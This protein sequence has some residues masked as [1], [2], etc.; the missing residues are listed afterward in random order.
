LT[1]S[2][3]A[4]EA[5]PPV[6]GPHRSSPCAARTSTG[7]RSATLRIALIA[8][9]RY[10][11]REPFA[12]GLEAHSWQLARALGERG[13]DVCV[14]AGPGSDPDLHVHE[15]PPMP[16][17]SDA[18]RK[19]VSMPPEYFL[20]E[21]S[22]YLT[23]MLG[24]LDG[25]YDVVHNN[26]LHYLPIAMA[27]ALGCPMLTTLHTPPTPWIESA[28]AARP[29][30]RSRFAAVSRV[31]AEQW[32]PTIP[33]P[34]VV[35]NGIDLARW[36]PGPGGGVPVWSGRIVPEKGLDLAIE[37]AR[38]AGTGLRIAGPRPDAGYFA[39]C[40]EPR[41]GDGIEYLG[42]LDHRRLCS[43]VGSASVAVV[44]PRWE[45]PYGRG[46]LPDL[47]DG[48][49]GVLAPA[50][51]VVGLAAAIRGAARLGRAGVRRSAE[52]TCS[53]DVMVDRYERLYRR[54]IR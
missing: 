3:P 41:L 12:G 50:D 53:V 10:P 24:L 6:L 17:L 21:H 29:A 36:V 16:A 43:L 34:W 4:C 26:S 27:D 37:A 32:R 28:V 11:L 39:R 33:E 2:P 46:A 14:F 25:G 22:A 54:M 35:P 13:H 31:T 40:I 44:S 8:S 18:A 48:T 42:H 9:T 47:I 30:P 7:A 45:E 1:T 52:R 23:L 20:A 49:N 19:D 51:D 15:T 38:T 5:A